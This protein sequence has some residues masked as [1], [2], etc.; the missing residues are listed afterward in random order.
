M[1]E[2]RRCRGFVGNV[3]IRRNQV[4]V[5]NKAG[6]IALNS[7]SVDRDFGMQTSISGSFS[8]VTEEKLNISRKKT[9]EDLRN[10]IMSRRKKSLIML[11]RQKNRSHRLRFCY[12]IYHIN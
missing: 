4:L 5:R 2:F 6:K 10:S 1:L 9:E 7:G 8:H 12:P 3:Q 11:W